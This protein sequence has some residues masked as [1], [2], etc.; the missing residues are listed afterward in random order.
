[1]RRFIGK[2]MTVAAVFLLGSLELVRRILEM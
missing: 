2:A 1:M